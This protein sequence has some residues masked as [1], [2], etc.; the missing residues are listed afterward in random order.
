MPS[1]HRCLPVQEAHPLAPAPPALVNR[2]VLQP[3]LLRHYRRPA[4][5]T[6]FPRGSGNVGWLSEVVLRNLRAAFENSHEARRKVKRPIGGKALRERSS[7]SAPLAAC[8]LPLAA[9]RLPLAACRLPIG[10]RSAGARLARRAYRPRR[11]GLQWPLR[12]ARERASPAAV[13][14]CECGGGIRR[15]DSRAQRAAAQRI[16]RVARWARSQWGGQRTA[17][18]GMARATDIRHAPLSRTN[19]AVP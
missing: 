18:Q 5:R 9:C 7:S 17:A 2:R 3:C 13:D 12:M 1:R 10:G 6:P 11:N 4:N 8:R 19:T 15:Q 16:A 14:C